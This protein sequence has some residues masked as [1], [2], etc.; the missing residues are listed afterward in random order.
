VYDKP[1]DDTDQAD[2]ICCDYGEG[3]YNV[4]SYG[5]II[6]EGGDFKSSESTVF[7]IPFVAP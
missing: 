6:K 1:S 5:E 2:G 7:S 3:N 4:T